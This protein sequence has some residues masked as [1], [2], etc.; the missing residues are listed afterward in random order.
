MKKL[1]LSILLI[2]CTY[3]IYSQYSN[4]IVFSEQ[5]E[6]FYLILDGVQQN[7]EAETNV[8]VF[9]IYKDREKALKDL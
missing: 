4:L 7:T 5:G 6:K 1:I 9:D 2:L 3:F 8:K